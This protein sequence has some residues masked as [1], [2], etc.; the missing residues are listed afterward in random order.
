MGRRTRRSKDG[1]GNE[2]VKAQP[3]PAGLVVSQ[4][5][6][7]Q[8]IK[9]LLDDP[10]CAKEI[11]TK[12]RPLMLQ[13]PPGL[14]ETEGPD[15]SVEKQLPKSQVKILKAFSKENR[16]CDFWQSV[17]LRAKEKDTTQMYM[18]TIWPVSKLIQPQLRKQFSQWDGVLDIWTTGPKEIRMKVSNYRTQ[19]ELTARARWLK[20]KS[21]KFGFEAGPGMDLAA[22][23]KA[24]V[25]PVILNVA[26]FI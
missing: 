13:R 6:L 24:L 17:E 20:Q 25:K 9:E 3:K 8:R 26:D 19:V 2:E 10:T 7:L 5:A 18:L 21:S 22:E 4:E 23:A 16:D 12:V 15:L 14:W 11:E 1:D